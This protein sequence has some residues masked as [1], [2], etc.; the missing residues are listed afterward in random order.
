MAKS[1][2]VAVND[3]TAVGT[4]INA[5]VDARVA[6]DGGVGECVLVLI[7]VDPNPG[8]SGIVGAIDAPN[9]KHLCTAV[10]RRVF[11]ERSRLA[12]ADRAGRLYA[13]NLKNE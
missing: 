8:K 3:S 10:Q 4:E 9:A 7:V 5:P 13:H 6:G 11:V 2:W 1:Y 12:E